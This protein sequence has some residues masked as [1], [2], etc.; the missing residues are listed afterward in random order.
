MLGCAGIGHFFIRI[1][2][3]PAPLLPGL[4]LGPQLEENVRRAMLLSDGNFSVF[5]SRPISA[6]A[7]GGGRNPFARHAFAGDFATPEGRAGGIG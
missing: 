1:G 3:E 4:V 7:A 5:L 2:V 6:R